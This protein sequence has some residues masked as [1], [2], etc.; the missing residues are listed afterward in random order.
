MILIRNS[1]GSSRSSSVRALHPS[2]HGGQG[3]HEEAEHSVRRLTNPDLFSMED[4]NMIHTTT[5]ER[6]MQEG[7]SYL[8][9]FTGIDLRRTE[10]AMVFAIQL[11]S[12]ENLIGQH[13]IADP[14]TVATFYVNLALN[15]LST[16][17]GRFGRRTVYIVGL[18][19]MVIVLLIIGAL[20][21]SDSDGAKW[22]SHRGQRAT[23]M[24]SHAVDAFNMHPI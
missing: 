15:S 21:F 9:C 1:W 7:M 8:Q 14:G 4:A 17:L 3:R 20:G 16:V 13:A 6:E 2:P 12:R 19:A 24:I 10:I 5:I 23:H 22:A 11:L 18:V